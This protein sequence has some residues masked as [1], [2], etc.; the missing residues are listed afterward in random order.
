[1]CHPISLSV[2]PIIVCGTRE[3]RLWHRTAEE[4]K[5]GDCLESWRVQ[6]DMGGKKGCEWRKPIVWIGLVFGQTGKRRMCTEK[7]YTL[8][9][10]VE[11]GHG[12]IN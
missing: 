6:I 7:F 4:K 9:G 8:K 5:I 2:V 12:V 11:K 1:M 3:A 10:C